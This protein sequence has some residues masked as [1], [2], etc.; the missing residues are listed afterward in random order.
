MQFFIFLVFMSFVS[1]SLAYLS[2]I[3]VLRLL[4]A[5]SLYSRYAQ[6]FLIPI[7]IVG[8]DFLT[9]VSGNIYLVG[10]LPI[11]IGVAL[12]LYFYFKMRN[13]PPMELSPQEERQSRT[14]I[15][16]GKKRKHNK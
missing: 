11:L 2:Y 13:Q 9:I 1:F 14:R 15:K 5:D 3:L 7:V 8:Y 6:I 12:M 10:S 4:G 16:P